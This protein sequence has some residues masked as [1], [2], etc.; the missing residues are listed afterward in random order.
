MLTLSNLD[1]EVVYVQPFPIF[2]HCLGYPYSCTSKLSLRRV[3]FS[4]QY[5]PRI[6]T[7]FEEL[8]VGFSNIMGG[9]TILL[10]R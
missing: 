10:M 5:I 4:S 9:I 2:V 8:I 1:L 7:F 6:W 3:G